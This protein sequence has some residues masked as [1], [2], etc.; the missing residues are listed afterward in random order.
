[1][2][3][4]TDA[5]VTTEQVSTETKTETP[6]SV[7]NTDGTFI[8]NWH[9]KAPDGYE[10]LRDDKSLATI[11]SVWDIG[12]SYRHIRKQVP[13][14]KT[15]IPNDN[16]T[17]ADWE[18]W[19]KHGGRPDTAA[20]YN[21]NKRPEEIPENLWDQKVADEW[22]EFFHKH[23]ASKKLV[24]AIN[25]RNTGLAV[26]ALAKQTQD[27][28]IATN[29]VSDALRKDWGP[30]YDQNCHRGEVAVSKDKDAEID[31]AYKVRLL[32]K[33]N[34]DPDLIRFASNMGY[35]FVEHKIVEDPG[36]PSVG[37]IQQRIDEAMGKDLTK[38]QRMEHPYFNK[39]HPSHKHQVEVVSALFREK[40]KYGQT[41]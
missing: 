32:D 19:N 41:G 40:A 18:V 6:A 25:E 13:L 3:E 36:I 21:I 5:S 16:W 24:E 9:T 20:D 30:A 28:E 1:M 34:K 15:A 11:K 29:A 10:E 27:Q 39:Q 14:D 17:D 7:V 33:I 8:E 35:K 26:A 23:G 37:D 31:P 22:Q 4:E 12:K 38:E 2:S